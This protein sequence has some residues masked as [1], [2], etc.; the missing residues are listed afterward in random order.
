MLVVK[1]H[2]FSKS[3]TSPIMWSVVTQGSC[4]KGKHGVEESYLREKSNIDAWWMHDIERSQRGDWGVA[5]WASVGKSLARWKARQGVTTG[6]ER[7]GLGQ[8]L[9]IGGYHKDK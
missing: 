7:R 1:T 6:C 9:K 8:G 5:W 2:G 4:L 3:S